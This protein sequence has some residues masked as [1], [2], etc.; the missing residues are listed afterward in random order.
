MRKLLPVLVVLLWA[1]SAGAWEADFRGASADVLTGASKP[2]QAAYGMTVL[3]CQNGGGG[4]QAI[5][6]AV[7]PT[8]ATSPA[9]T[10][11]LRRSSPDGSPA[12]ATCDQVC[13]FVVGPSLLSEPL[14]LATL[15]NSS[16]TS[17]SGATVGSQY[18]LTQQNMGQIT[19]NTYTVSTGV[20]P[21]GTGPGG[22]T[23]CNYGELYLYLVRGTGGGCTATLDYT[24]LSVL[25]N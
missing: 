23:E 24:S 18:I 14:Q 11:I 8:V 9:I 3:E 22:A 5:F 15:A 19:P 2:Y 1:G 20:H 13:A 17:V 12:G 16:C 25:G 6:H 4:C 7:M 21:C 10:P